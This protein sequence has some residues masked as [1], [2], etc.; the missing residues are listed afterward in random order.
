[1]FNTN[2]IKN[3]SN[4][5][6]EVLL[7]FKCKSTIAAIANK[8]YINVINKYKNIIT[9][10]IIKLKNTNNIN[11]KY[12]FGKSILSYTDIYLNCLNTNLD[13]PI[14]YSKIICF[15]GIQQIYINSNGDISLCET[16]Y[17]QHKYVLANIYTA[18]KFF[19]SNSAYIC[20]IKCSCPLLSN[21]YL[22]N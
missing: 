13:I 16:K 2:F 9:N 11:Y 19:I 22:Y 21:K 20:D 18:T 3:I 12:I 6:L 1:M 4:S 8:S 15:S 5:Q 17:F 10:Y 7:A 14:K